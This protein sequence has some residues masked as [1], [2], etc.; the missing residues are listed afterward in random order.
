MAEPTTALQVAKLISRTLL[1]MTLIV[2]LLVL[3]TVYIQTRTGGRCDYGLSGRDPRAYFEPLTAESDPT[4]VGGAAAQK[5]MMPISIR[6]SGRAG[7]R[8]SD[9]IPNKNPLILYT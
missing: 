1:L 5:K 9:R 2:S 6:M 3:V 8:I 4:D 7:V